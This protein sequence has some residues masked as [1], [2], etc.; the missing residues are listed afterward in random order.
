VAIAR[1]S[2]II[3]GTQ[4]TTVASSTNP[5][6]PAAGPGAADASD[7]AQ[8]SVATQPQIPYI[9]CGITLAVIGF[10]LGLYFQHK[11]HPKMTQLPVIASGF[12]SVTLIYIVAQAIERALVPISWFGGG[13]FGV[14]T[15]PPLTPK[16]ALKNDRQ[17]A[18]LQAERMEAADPAGV[19]TGNPDAAQAPDPAGVQADD[20]LQKAKGAAKEKADTQHNL[21]QYRANLTGITFGVSAGLAMAV[22]G[23]AGIFLL[24]TVGITTAPW[25]DLLVTGLVIAGGT[26]PLHDL[27]SNISS[28]SQSKDSATFK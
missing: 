21:D 20:P 19:Q 6:K 8:Q 25:L 13:I 10:L 15:K 5:N 28:S 26:K 17:L 22:C 27:I 1:V 9:I 18:L 2:T 7:T 4:S 14:G 23:Y 12:G 3:N 16:Y 11:L 24:K